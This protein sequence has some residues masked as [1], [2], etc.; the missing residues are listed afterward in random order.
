MCLE[1]VPNWHIVRV[2]E[3]S[4]TENLGESFGNDMPGPQILY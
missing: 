1:E 2:L 3:K 4:R